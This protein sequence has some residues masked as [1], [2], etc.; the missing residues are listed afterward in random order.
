MKFSL[1]ACLCAI[2]LLSLL[3]TA[4]P[5]QAGSKPYCIAYARDLANRKVAP[6][7]PWINRRLNLLKS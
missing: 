6:S 4:P 7:L 1:G 5:S 3:G 2:G